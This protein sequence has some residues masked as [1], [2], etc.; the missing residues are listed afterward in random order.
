[1][2]NVP[3]T[4]FWLLWK[5]N[6]WWDGSGMGWRQGKYRYRLE[7]LIWRVVVLGVVPKNLICRSGYAVTGNIRVGFRDRWGGY[8]ALC[9]VLYERDPLPRDEKRWV[10]GLHEFTR[11]NAAADRDDYERKP[12]R[13]RPFPGVNRRN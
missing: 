2:D 6:G 7:T 10:S 13:D 1:M 8:T 12:R 9:F 4:L 11:I 3:A 5:E